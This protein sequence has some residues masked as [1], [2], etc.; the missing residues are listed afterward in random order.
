MPT[1]LFHLIAIAVAVYAV[2]KGFR[3]RFTRQLASVLGL[4]F[5]SVSAHMAMEPLEEWMRD[6]LPLHPD[7]AVASFVYSVTAVA[8]VYTAVFL[9]FKILGPLLRSAMMVLDAGM[10]DSLLGAAFSLWKYLLALSIAY[11]LYACFDPSSPLVKYAADDDGNVIE[12]VMH[13]APLMLGCEDVAELA[14]SLQLRDAR[15]ISINLS[16]PASVNKMDRP[17]AHVRSVT[18]APAPAAR[19]APIYYG[20]KIFT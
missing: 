19:Q 1:A 14:H 8:A 15:K 5:G 9:L 17:T 2:V 20:R 10:L 16:P 6:S 12:A 3:V 11:N 4:A 18:T 7:P 13:V